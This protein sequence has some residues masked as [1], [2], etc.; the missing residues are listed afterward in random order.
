MSLIKVAARFDKKAAVYGKKNTDDPRE[1]YLTEDLEEKSNT[2]DS[3]R[4]LSLWNLKR[5]LSLGPSRASEPSITFTLQKSLFGFLIILYH[6]V[7]DGDKFSYE[8]FGLRR[9]RFYATSKRSC[10]NVIHEYHI[11]ANKPF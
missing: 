2:E 10:Y 4:T 11:I 9:P 8:N 3:N 5:T 7:G 1:E 6:R